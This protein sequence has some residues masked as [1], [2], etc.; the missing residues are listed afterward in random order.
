[1]PKA[2]WVRGL[3]TASV[4]ALFTVSAIVL[5]RQLKPATA[6]S[7]RVV[8]IGCTNVS[9]KTAANNPALLLSPLSSSPI[10]KDAEFKVSNQGDRPVRIEKGIIIEQRPAGM[11]DDLGLNVNHLLQTNLFGSTETLES[12]ETRTFIVRF[13][14]MGGSYLGGGGQIQYELRGVCKTSPAEPNLRLMRWLKEQAWSKYL[15]HGLFKDVNSYIFSSA[16][17]SNVGTGPASADSGLM[18]DNR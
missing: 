17:T 13:W 7:L 18:N 6:P 3:I 14:S 2:N 15:P 10:Q 5:L 4:V 9:V 8:L 11:S 1:M 16:W 12:G